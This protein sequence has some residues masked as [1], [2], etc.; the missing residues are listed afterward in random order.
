MDYY[1]TQI[2]LFIFLIGYGVFF[3]DLH[4]LFLAWLVSNNN[5]NNA[6]RRADYYYYRVDR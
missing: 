2:E 5:N 6:P 4:C 1:P 3:P